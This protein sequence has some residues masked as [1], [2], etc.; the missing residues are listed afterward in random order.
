MMTKAVEAVSGSR[1]PSPAVS[2]LPA[3]D[4]GY[5]AWRPALA[6][7]YRAEGSFQSAENV[8][9]HKLPLTDTDKRYIDA[10]RAAYEQVAA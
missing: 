7:F 8:G 5:E 2:A 4:P 10:L 6:A 1:E 3:V 9:K